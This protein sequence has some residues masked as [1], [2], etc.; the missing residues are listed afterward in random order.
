MRLGLP[1]LL[2]L[3]ACSTP[4]PTDSGEADTAPVDLDGDGADATVDCDD[5]DATVFPG[6]VEVAHDGI[7]NDCDPGTCH[8]S[9]FAAGAT[10][11]AL[12]AVYG[13]AGTQPFDQASGYASCADGTPAHGVADVSGDGRGDLVVTFLCGD[14]EATGD[15]RWLVHGGAEAGFNDVAADWTLPD[16]YG[17]AGAAPFANATASMVCG[18]GIPGHFVRDLDGDGFPDL[19]VTELCDDDAVGTTSWQVHLGTAAGFTVAPTSWALPAGFGGEG[20]AAFSAASANAAC[21]KGIPG[22]ALADADGDERPDLVILE[23]CTDPTVGSTH[24]LIA[25]NTGSGFGATAPHTL[26]SAYVE[27]GTLSFPTASAPASCGEGSPGHDVTDLDG[28]GVP[29]L[30]VTEACDGDTAVGDTVWRVYPGAAGGFADTAVEWALPAEYG[31]A[32]TTPFSSTRE[33]ASGGDDTPG[34]TLVDLDGDGRRDLLLTERTADPTLGAS[35]WAVHYGTD[36]GFAAAAADWALPPAA[37]TTP[38]GA[39]RSA[40]DC[41]AS[42]PAWSL[43]DLD[44]DVL[45]DLLVTADCADTALGDTHWNVYEADCTQ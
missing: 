30:V 24:W 16:D 20:F 39:E 19:V 9:G 18:D 27:A 25:P 37:G 43:T 26:P 23:S 33:I 2:V 31:A 17:S 34:H 14:D 11:Y 21:L 38:F 42:L 36:G 32:D 44:G 12:P 29:D 45:P 7:D 10:A 28:D 8:G 13:D 22:Y 4:A 41:S 35:R 6:A 1:V 3:A 15:T 40:A 5:E